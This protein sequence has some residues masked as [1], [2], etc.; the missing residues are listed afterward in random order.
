M[1]TNRVGPVKPPARISV[2]ALGT[3][4]LSALAAFERWQRESPHAVASPRAGDAGHD[5]APTDEPLK[6]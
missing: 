4:H 5:P 1:K 3:D 6:N 2:A